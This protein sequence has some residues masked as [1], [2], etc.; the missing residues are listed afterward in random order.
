M[1]PQYQSGLGVGVEGCVCLCVWGRGEG[2][3]VN[4]LIWSK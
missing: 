3:E 1:H 2:L 4:C